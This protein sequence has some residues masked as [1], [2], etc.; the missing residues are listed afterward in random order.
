MT[1]LIVLLLASAIF[2]FF[3]LG[4]LVDGNINRCDYP[5]TGEVSE[6]AKSL[7]A[8]LLIADMHADSFL[9]DRNFLERNQ[10]G[11][12]DLPRMLEG[13]AALQIFDAVTQTPRGLN[14][15]RNDDRTDN[16]TLLTIANRRPPRSWFSLKERALHNA[17]L[18]HKAAANS[19]G[20]FS[21]IKNQ[22]ELNAFLEKR[23]HSLKMAAGM[24]A[25]EGLHALEGRL[26]NL[27]VL[28]QAG[29]RMMGLVHFFDNDAGGSSTGMQKG[30]LTDF[31]KAAVRKMEE[32]YITV[33]LA[34]ASE[35]L[36]EDVLA[37]SHK[38][39]VVSHTGL[40]GTK[41]SLRNLSDAHL[42]AVAEKGGLIGIGYWSEA[43]CDIS[44]AGIAKTI[45]Y[46]VNRAGVEHIA[47]GS[48]F[49]G[50]VA[51]QFDISSLV[52]LTDALLKE[53]FEEE[54]VAQIMGGNQIRFLQQWLPA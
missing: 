30:G 2:F 45:R 21:V 48:D 49:D 33:D 51:T 19:A 3:F 37:Y 14:Y 23:I 25:V 7:H 46:A 1:V 32:L 50:A 22:K 53:G 4:K 39:V 31:G 28:H 42:K 35:Q 34:H 15:D 27:E 36:I 11:H 5:G 18:V 17:E 43:V 8:K 52:L 26:E 12:I 6:K 16:I 10:R 54:E 38:P 29:Y 41:D 40:R 24:L 13:N 9:W 47:L 20:R 44:P